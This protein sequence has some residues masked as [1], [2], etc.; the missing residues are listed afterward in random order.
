MYAEKTD[1]EL[2]GHV[3]AIPDAS[4]LSQSLAARIKILVAEREQQA[5]II[6][7]LKRQVM[8]LELGIARD[9]IE[10]YDDLV[11]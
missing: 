7:R 2:V 8:A 9:K 3:F 1:M 11:K 10:A 4:E 6:Q 5:Q